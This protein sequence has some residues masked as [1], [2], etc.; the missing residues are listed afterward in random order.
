M[1]KK[2]CFREAYISVNRILRCFPV[3]SVVYWGSIKLIWMIR[4]AVM[5]RLSDEGDFFEH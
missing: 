3:D 2:A 5:K 4:V 1:T